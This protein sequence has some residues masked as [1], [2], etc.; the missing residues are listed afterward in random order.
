MVVTAPVAVGA[1]AWGR[2]VARPHASA[3]GTMSPQYLC[4]TSVSRV[5]FEQAVPV[6]LISG[7]RHEVHAYATQVIGRVQHARLV[8]PRAVLDGISL[9]AVVRPRRPVEPVG[10][11]EGDVDAGGGPTQDLGRDHPAAH[12]EEALLFVRHFDTALVAVLVPQVRPSDH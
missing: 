3:T 1:A 5:L 6:Q 4:V 10:T 11:G 7:N 9:V 2:G 8:A 12:V